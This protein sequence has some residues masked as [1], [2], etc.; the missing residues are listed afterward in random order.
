M[1]NP[2]R[3]LFPCAGFSASQKMLFGRI[4]KAVERWVWE[5]GYTKPLSTVSEVAADIGIPSDQ[6]N[7][8]VRL[9]MRT[10][11]LSWRKTLRIREACRLLR[12]FP[13]LPL[14]TVGEMVGIDDKSNFKRQFA[15]EVG[16]SPRAWREKF[17]KK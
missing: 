9:H 6:L 14:S 8:F 4:G 16:M 13:D 10:T 2:F 5:K 17:R 1:T 11:V 15:E 3:K 12:A 7:I